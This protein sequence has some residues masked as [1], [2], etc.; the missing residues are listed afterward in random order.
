MLD[1]TD[2]II[3][4]QPICWLLFARVRG[5]PPHT[6]KALTRERF[7]CCSHRTRACMVQTDCQ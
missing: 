7:A 4:K 1:S 6:F 2:H 5:A 3:A